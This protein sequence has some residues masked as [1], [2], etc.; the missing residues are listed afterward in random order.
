MASSLYDYIV[1]PLGE[2][3]NNVKKVNGKSLILN[4]KI[5]TFNSVNKT[6]K[7]ISIPKNYKLPIEV[8][9]IVHIHH[10][11]FRKFY[12]MKGKKQNSRSYFK[13]NLYFCSPDQI[14]MYERNNEIKTFLDR[15]FV[16]PLLSNKLGEKT[17][18][19]LGI[20]KYSNKILK[21]LGI[22]VNDLVSFPKLRE[23]E[24]EID[25]EILYCMKSKDILIKHEY[26]GNEKEY[27]PSGTTCGCGANQS[28]ERTDSRHGRRCDC[29]SFE[30]C[31]CNKKTSNI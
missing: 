30:E 24:F 8:G 6:A 31:R 29:G 20:L 27:N 10:N 12:N 15:C 9:D 13:D 4:T 28:C 21:S 25:S 7:V 23:W 1:E 5:E 11:V 14:Y 3:Y 22:E 2:R 18:P 17:I 26:E 16:K 19:N